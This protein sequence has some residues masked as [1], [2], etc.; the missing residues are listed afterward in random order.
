MALLQIQHYPEVVLTEKSA[1]VVEF[2]AELRTLAANMVET[3]YAAPGVG[4]AAPQVAVLTRLVVIDC[5]DKEDPKLIV[6]VNPEIIER[7]GESYE[8]EGCLSVPD[9]YAHIKRSEWVRVRFQNLQGDVV[10]FETKGLLAICF[11]HEIDH[12]DG[13]LFVDR[14]SSLKKGIFRKKYQKIMEQQQEQL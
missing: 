1:P 3:M 14:L 10:E 6:A 13:K 12:L 2:N 5:G 9:Y 8:E 4:L 7:D 11:Q